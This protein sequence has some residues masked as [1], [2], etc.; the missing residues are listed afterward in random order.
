MVNSVVWRA[1]WRAPYFCP[2]LLT[3]FLALLP[4]FAVIPGRARREGGPG[5]PPHFVLSRTRQE[6]S[7]HHNT[8]QLPQAQARRPPCGCFA[9]GGRAALHLRLRSLSSVKGE[10]QATPVKPTHKRAT[11]SPGGPQ[12]PSSPPCLTRMKGTTCVLLAAA[13]ATWPSWC[14]GLLGSCQRCLPLVP[15]KR[16]ASTCYLSRKT[17]R[18]STYKLSCCCCCCCC[19][20]LAKIILKEL[21]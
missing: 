5:G 2:Y 4:V 21:S 8:S 14:T 9:L 10:S 19:L 17:H 13:R 3:C 1:L 15:G 16:T 7:G 12:P 11:L 6:R 20:H 18:H